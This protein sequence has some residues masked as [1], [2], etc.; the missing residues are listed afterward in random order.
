M[1]TLRY[2]ELTA[3]DIAALRILAA[4]DKAYPNRVPTP[5]KHQPS[6]VLA[7]LEAWRAKRGLVA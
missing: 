5:G 2:S 1:T 6:K 3:H 7:G 4:I